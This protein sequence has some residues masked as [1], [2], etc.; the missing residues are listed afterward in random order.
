MEWKKIGSREPVAC[1]H[2]PEMLGIKMLSFERKL[3]EQTWYVY[4]SFKD[5]LK[6]LN[7]CSNQ[8][9]LITQRNKQASPEEG[10]ANHMCVKFFQKLKI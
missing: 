3:Q 6:I 5:S 1:C 4:Y 10:P 9:D 7:W 8:M 2:S